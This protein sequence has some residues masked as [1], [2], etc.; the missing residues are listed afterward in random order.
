MTSLAVLVLGM[1]RSG[2]SLATEI[3]R[4]LGLWLGPEQGLIGASDGNPRGHFELLAGVEFDNEVLRLAGGSWDGPP[5]MSSI[6]AL[7]TTMRPAVDL[8]FEGRA[9]LAF[10]DPR[11]C[12]TLP[13]WM[14]ALAG[15]DVRIVHLFRDPQAV[16]RSL[17]TRNEASDIPTSRF[18]KG[19][20][21]AA[22]ALALWGEYNS[23]A[24]RYAD[25]FGIR[26]LPV[27]YDA[28][29]EAPAMQVRR[30]AAFV[31]RGY[32]EIDAAIECVR[33]ELN[34]NGGIP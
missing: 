34:R 11:L 30:I 12:L 22:D 19:D 4:E 17:V 10:K 14:P 27:W 21:T 13:V 20:M 16:A 33:P 24:C 25:Q 9:P 23:R 32:D 2:T 29:I 18:A 5:V 8:W 15:Y 3:L 6:D 1:H 26:R 31:D 7:A 28:L